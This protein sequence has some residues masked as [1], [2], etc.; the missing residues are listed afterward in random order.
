MKAVVLRSTVRSH[1]WVSIN[2]SP[3]LK[4][5]EV[6]WYFHEEFVCWTIS[7]L[8]K[9]K[10]LKCSLS[11]SLLFT[12]SVSPIP[13]VKLLDREKNKKKSDQQGG[14]PLTTDCVKWKHTPSST[15][16]L[17]FLGS[18]PVKHRPCMQSVSQ[19]VRVGNGGTWN[20]LINKSSWLICLTGRTLQPVT[21]AA[22]VWWLGIPPSH[23]LTL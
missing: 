3:G 4:M 18:T 14:V 20:L 15:L 21:E 8:K 19:S 7:K 13:L 1:P 2:Q 16:I 11:G 6:C 17:T 12:E 22:G 23:H 9:L 10:L 5:F